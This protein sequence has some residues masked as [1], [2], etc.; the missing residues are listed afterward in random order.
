[1]EWNFNSVGQ[2]F[3]VAFPGARLGGDA[4]L[5]PCSPSIPMVGT[6]ASG[7]TLV[8]TPYVFY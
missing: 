1:M 6:I 2:P 4:R 8:M 5:M 3:R 7:K